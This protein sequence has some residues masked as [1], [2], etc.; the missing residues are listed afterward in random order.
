MKRNAWRQTYCRHV[1][2]ICHNH[3]GGRPV[4]KLLNQTLH[5]R[6]EGQVD[7]QHPVFG[8]LEDVRDLR[9]EQPRVDGVDHRP[10]AGDGEVELVVAV[11]V[12]GQRADPVTRTNA[13]P[14]QYP[15]QP[16]GA[17]LGVAV[18]VTVARA[19]ERVADDLRLA[20]MPRGEGEQRRDQQRLLL[21]QAQH[22]ARSQPR[23]RDRSPWGS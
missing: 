19:L 14:L 10:H 9:L 3:R 20:M 8:M 11:A 17:P 12:P 18:G 7:K 2:A 1:L 6:H 15:G 23:V 16:A 5:Q 13:Q 21:H 22:G 4:A